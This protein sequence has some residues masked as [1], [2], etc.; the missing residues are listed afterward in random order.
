MVVR[1][2]HSRDDEEPGAVDDLGALG[3]V[4]DDPAAGNRDVGASELTRADVDET[5]AEQQLRQAPAS[6]AT[7]ATASVGMASSGT[8]LAKPSP[9]RTRPMDRTTATRPT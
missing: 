1:V 6:V 7:S 4:H 8:V 9:S 5:V 3:R 2:D